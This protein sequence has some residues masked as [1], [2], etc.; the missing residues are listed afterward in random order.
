MHQRTYETPLA[1]DVDAIRCAPAHRKEKPPKLHCLRRL[2]A[3]IAPLAQFRAK[4]AAA[5]A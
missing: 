4:L 5:L 2:L 3:L 1:L